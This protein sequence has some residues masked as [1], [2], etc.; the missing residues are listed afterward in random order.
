MLQIFK[1]NNDNIQT[2]TLCINTKTLKKSLT[3]CH[4]RLY[5]LLTLPIFVG[6]DL[7]KYSKIMLFQL[8]LRRLKACPFACLHGYFHCFTTLCNLQQLWVCVLAGYN[9]IIVC[10]TEKCNADVLK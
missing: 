4:G 10:I 6:E 1:I 8:V 5:D 9:I 7:N 3:N 2:K